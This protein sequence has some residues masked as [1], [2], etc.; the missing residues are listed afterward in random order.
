MSPQPPSEF[1]D[2]L[3]AEVD[4]IV[5][6]GMAKEKE[7]RHATAEELV[8][9]LRELLESN[10]L[11]ESSDRKLVKTPRPVPTSRSIAYARRRRLW[12]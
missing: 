1:V 9:D 6:R 2:G 11:P 8:A 10:A 7:D 12:G 5:L 4:S 3:P